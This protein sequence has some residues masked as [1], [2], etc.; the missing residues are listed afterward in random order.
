MYPFGSLHTWVD[1]AI[2]MIYAAIVLSCVV[3]VLKENRNPIRALAWTIALLF[4]PLVGLI[5]YLF[6]V[7]ASAGSI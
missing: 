6:S 7:A 2:F 5:F 4:L 3:V 1:F